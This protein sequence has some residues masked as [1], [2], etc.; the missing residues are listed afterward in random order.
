MCVCVGGDVEHTVDREGRTHTHTRLACL[1]GDSHRVCVVGRRLVRSG[2][3]RKCVCC[4]L[5]SPH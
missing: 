1:F 5:T 4:F 3:M 2:G